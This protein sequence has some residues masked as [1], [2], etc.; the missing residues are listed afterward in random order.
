VSHSP[1]LSQILQLG[2][3]LLKKKANPVALPMNLEIRTLIEQLWQLMVRENGVGIAAPQIGRSHQVMIIASRPNL[4][5]P[6]APTM[7]PLPMINPKIVS[8]SEDRC[9]G[10]EGCLSV[11]GIRGNINRSQSVTVQ[12]F[13]LDSRSHQETFRGFVARVIQHEYDHLL[14]KVFLDHVQSA[15]QLLSDQEYFRQIL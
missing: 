9:Q 10:W 6:H 3:P 12:Y 7:D 4:R 14:G 15:D 11:P 1:E 13:D 2:H 8:Y 5:Y